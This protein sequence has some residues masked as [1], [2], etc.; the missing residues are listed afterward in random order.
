ML[1]LIRR[2]LYASEKPRVSSSLSF[3]NAKLHSVSVWK[4]WNKENRV[5]KA[6]RWPVAIALS[7]MIS[8]VYG[9]Q[10]LTVIYRER[11]KSEVW[12][13]ILRSLPRIEPTWHA[14]QNEIGKKKL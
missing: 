12:S 7:T 10:R 2:R 1:S 13:K 5:D 9:S 4:N 3:D 11:P 6:D 8:D 14:K